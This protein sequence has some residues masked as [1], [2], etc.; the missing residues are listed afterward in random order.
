MF[1]GAMTVYGGCYNELERVVNMTVK[2][3][4]PSLPK[5][6]NFMICIAELITE[7]SVLFDVLAI[8]A[9]TCIGRSLLALL[10]ES[11]G[12]CLAGT[13]SLVLALCGVERIAE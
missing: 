12:C 13:S 5:N 11:F 7:Y 4:L 8:H 9:S 1:Y 3:I 6:N 10:A 2:V